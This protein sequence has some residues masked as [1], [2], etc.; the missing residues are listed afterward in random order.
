ME[1]KSTGR[2]QCFLAEISVR[3]PSKC[4]IILFSTKMFSGS[5]YTKNRCMYTF[6]ENR[7]TGRVATLYSLLPHPHIVST[8]GS[9]VLGLPISFLFFGE[10]LCPSATLITI[11]FRS[12]DCGDH[13]DRKNSF[14]SGYCDSDCGLACTCYHITLNCRMASG[15][16]N[17]CLQVH[18]WLPMIM[19]A[20]QTKL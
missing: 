3:L 1:K 4:Y 11:R 10:R 18:S 15:E 20:V 6:F 17:W 19:S 2:V 9:E 5:T 7:S 12:G 16:K 13:W 14:I 8:K